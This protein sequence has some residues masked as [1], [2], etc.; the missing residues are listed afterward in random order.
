M[1]PILLRSFY[2][3]PVWGGPRIAAARGIDWTKD[4]CLG[5]AFDVSAHPT[6]EG[7]VESGP[8]SGMC[9][10]EAI[11]AHRVEILGDVPEDEPI[12]VTFM[13]AAQTLSVQV[14]PDE[15]YAQ[16]AEGDHGKVESWYIL[17][18]EP[19]AT[20]IA[21]SE[22]VT[23]DQLRAAA[24]DDTIGERYG[25]RIA[26]S[27]GDFVLI[28]SGLMHAIGA[29]ILAVEVATFGNTTYRLCDWGRGRELHVEKALDVVDVTLKPTVTHC[30]AYDADAGPC[31]R[32]GVDSEAFRSYVV[33]V[34]GRRSYSCE[35]RYAVLTC[36]NGAVSV[37]CGDG[38]VELGYTR[39]CLVP[40]CA[41][42]YELEG[43]GRVL[44]SVRTP[45]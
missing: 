7:V 1:G 10:S 2:V 40:A 41:G 43:H 44:R 26:V 23:R 33:D 5:E 25:H 36:V 16:A 13:D 42:S 31:E 8:C 6:T 28:P 12:Q 4:A 21:G 27:E 17:A 45:R 22:A 11:A 32:L 29:G 14:H 38:G 37:R 34:A 19:G 3:S 18:A 24:A 20:L 35:G 39:S 30:G 9:L 15:A